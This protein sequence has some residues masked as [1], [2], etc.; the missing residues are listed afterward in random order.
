[1]QFYVNPIKCR[2]SPGICE[3]YIFVRKADTQVRNLDLVFIFGYILLIGSKIYTYKEFIDRRVE[4]LVNFERN[5]CT[6]YM[7]KSPGTIVNS[8]YIFSDYGRD[9]QTQF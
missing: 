5:Y 8:N 6:V 7:P 4:S 2:E 3:A 9:S 1:M